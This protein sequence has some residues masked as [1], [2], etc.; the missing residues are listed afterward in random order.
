MSTVISIPRKL[1]E[2]AVKRGIDIESRIIELLAKDLGLDP[3][4]RL[5]SI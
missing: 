1:Y 5:L 3:G 2:E 4:T